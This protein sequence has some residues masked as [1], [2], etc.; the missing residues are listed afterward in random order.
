[1][2]RNISINQCN[3]IKIFDY[4]IGKSNTILPLTIPVNARVID[5]SSFNSSHSRSIYPELDWKSIDVQQISLDFFADNFLHGQKIDIVK[6]DVEDHELE[7]LEGMQQIIL[8]Y[9]PDIFFES[10]L[11]LEKIRFLN[12]LSRKH[13]YYSYAIMEDSL[14]FI[15]N[16][17]QTKGINFLLSKDKNPERA[18]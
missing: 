17:T 3:N 8:V 10:F 1:M 15:D 7:V 5:T 2:K 18:L 16:F 4:A 11:T 6:I 14:V 12:E 13:G 9:K